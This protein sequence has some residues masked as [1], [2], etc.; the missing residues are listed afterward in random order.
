MLETLVKKNRSY[1]GFDSSCKVTKE[2]LL[3]YVDLCRYCA[4]SLN[5]Q[6]LKFHVATE[7]KEV[8]DILALTG[9]AMAH[10]EYH[11]PHEGMGPV[12]FIVISIDKNL[13]A[14]DIFQRDVGVC[15]QTILLKATE[16][17]LGG[18][19]LGTFNK[20]KLKALLGFK[21]GV[22]PNLIV[23]LGKPKETVILED[24]QGDAI[25]YYRD[26]EDNHHVP[27]RSLED[28]LN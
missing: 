15:A 14:R 19:M 8:A 10:P 4:S 13:D 18:C 16:D 21:E 12:A 3:S 24:L 25:G 26:G 22:E 20:L 27:K 17:G 1:R 23:A 11:L 2:Q 6:P 28:I 9:W 7:E 5:K